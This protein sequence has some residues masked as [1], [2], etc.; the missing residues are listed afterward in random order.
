MRP[1]WPRLA[2]RL[3]V[4][5]GPPG[6]GCGLGWLHHERLGVA[7]LLIQL[8]LV[9]FGCIPHRLRGAGMRGSRLHGNDGGLGD[10]ISILWLN[11][12]LLAPFTPSG[13]AGNEATVASFGTTL[14]PTHCASVALDVATV[15]SLGVARSGETFN[16]VAF[17]CI[18]L[19]SLIVDVGQ[20]GTP[21]PAFS[22]QDLCVTAPGGRSS[23]HPPARYACGGHPTPPAVWHR[24]SALPLSRGYAS[25]PFEL[26]K[27]LLKGEGTCAFAGTTVVGGAT[28]GS[29]LSRW[30][31]T[32]SGGVPW[33]R[34]GLDRVGVGLATLLV[35]WHICNC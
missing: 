14:T 4:R 28:A 5:G 20:G 24:P 18:S 22:P 29:G 11:L 1:P 17:G 8:H 15:A 25:R 34:P 32:G 23:S 21:I 2:L 9:A 33:L 10:E 16:S 35:T 7:K 31:G 13:E 3:L 26:C 19:H 12:A 27:G 30:D 6:P